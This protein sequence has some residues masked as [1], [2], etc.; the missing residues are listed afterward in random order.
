MAPACRAV[1]V[2]DTGVLTW[3]ESTSRDQDFLRLVF[4]SAREHSAAMSRL[5]PVERGRALD[6]EFE[7]RQTSYRIDFPHVRFHVLELDGRAIGRCYLEDVPRGLFVVDLI[8]LPPWRGRGLGTV[9]LEGLIAEAG[10]T[11]R[12]VRLH[13]EKTNQ[14][15]FG[16]YLR[17]G[18]TV[19]GEL[20]L[21]RL[22][23]HPGRG[24]R[25]S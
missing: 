10:A 21:H 8:L 1:H 20:P 24:P 17:L 4:A 9:L 5:D 13:V 25:L 23:E 18:F 19:V 16:L 22:L 11:G 6:R 14:R 2:A 12:T 15:A 3:R 7:S